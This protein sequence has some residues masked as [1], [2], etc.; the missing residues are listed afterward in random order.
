MCRRSR[1]K[2]PP[3]NGSTGAPRRY[4]D[5][6]KRAALIVALLA[7][8][9]AACGRNAG[10][11]APPRVTGSVTFPVQTSTLVVPVVAPLVDIQRGLDAGTPRVLWRID[12]HR[13]NCIEP[14]RVD[15]GIAEVKTP[16]VGCRIVGRAERGAIRLSGEGDRLLITMPVRATVSVR[17]VAGV[18][19]ATATGTA[20]VRATARLGIAGNW[21]PRAKVDLTYR[22][23]Q[24]PAVNVLGQRITFADKAD[25]RLA[26]IVTQLERD[27]PRELAKL[28]LR[29]RLESVWQEAFTTIELNERKPPAWMRVTPQ[30]LGFGGYRVTGRDLQ[31]MLA[32]DA[33]T[34]T[35][36]GD[37]PQ[38]PAPTPL[39]PPTERLG[40]PGLRFYIPVL[41]DYAQLEP[42]VQRT[43]RKLAARGIT[44]K[45]IGAVDA[46]FGEVTVYA[47]TGGRIA[48][49]VKAKVKARAASFATT[50]GE[51]WLSAVPYNEPGSQL[52][53]ARDV[54]FATQTDSS[55][56]N[57]LVALFSDSA[58]QASIAQGLS[59]DFAP[60]YAKVL[61]A[62]Q[63]AIG[64]RQEG[65]FHISARITKVENGAIKATGA[66]L[67]MPVSATGTAR[68][69]Y[70][71]RS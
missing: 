25:E 69:A 53:R 38:D 10:N 52:V 28:D 37:R 32:A 20:L 4:A 18:A 57:L 33:L 2:S 46:D 68:I 14:K 29:R 55:L 36:V 43:L 64:D 5:V 51:A 47:T 58:V 13:S 45:G 50:S 41:A 48:V 70:A 34:E 62:A 19:G 56:V 71:P 59:H 16:S 15:L 54:R 60:D 66:G 27:L 67:Y 17:E 8:P 3:S 39:P 35:F 44:L 6:S 12:E 7:P 21:E 11:A 23:T 24:P 30:R 1:A 63:Q 61:R 42:V 65:D 31:L 40:A 22:W 9:L 26:S 49:G